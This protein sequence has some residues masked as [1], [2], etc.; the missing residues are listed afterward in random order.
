MFAY[1]TA[2]INAFHQRIMPQSYKYIYL[3]FVS[4]WNFNSIYI[5]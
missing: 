3:K 1:N 2:H 4:G 5:S